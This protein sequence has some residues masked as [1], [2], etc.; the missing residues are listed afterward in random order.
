MSH[1]ISAVLSILPLA[2]PKVPAPET[3]PPTALADRMERLGQALASYRMTLRV[4]PLGSAGQSDLLEE[5]W[6]VDG[7]RWSCRTLHFWPE[8]PDVKLAERL[9]EYS[10][11]V[12]VDGTSRT[13]FRDKSRTA[14]IER[15]A[16]RTSL[17]VVVPTDRLFLRPLGEGDFLDRPVTQV[18]PDGKVYRCL[19]RDLIL[20]EALKH[21]GWVVGPDRMSEGVL[22][23]T[24]RIGPGFEDR[25]WVD[26]ARGFALTAREFH[27]GGEA[28]IRL[29]FD[30]LR[31]L[32][33]GLWIP[34]VYRWWRDGQGFEQRITELTLGSPLPGELT[35]ALPPG[36]RIVDRRDGSVRYLPGGEDMLD[37]MADR[38][39]HLYLSPRSGGGRRGGWATLLPLALVPAAL[40]VVARRRTTNSEGRCGVTLIE[41]LVVIAVIGLLAG[42]LLPGVQSAR[43]ASRR[44]WCA[45]NLRQIG[46]AIHNYEG[47]HRTLPSGRPGR[48][49]PDDVHTGRSVF[50][51]ILPSVGATPVY[52][53]YNFSAMPFNLANATAEMARP[54]LL[55]CP[56]DPAS[57]GPQPGGFGARYPAPDPPSGEWPVMLASYTPLYGTLHYGWETRPNPAYD[58]RGQINGCFND[59]PSITPAG[60]T[61]GLSNTMF[62]SE[63][64]LSHLNAD[65]YN[66]VG[67]WVD[68]FGGA[69]L[70]FATLPPN[71]ALR[72]SSHHPYYATLQVSASSFHPGGVHAL[73]GDGSA[74]F[75]KETIDSWPIDPDRF[76]VVGVIPLPDGYANVPRSGVWQALTTRSGGEAVTPP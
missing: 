4:A 23:L 64:A 45:N 26:P 11:Q 57:H 40:V 44:A 47:T 76:A 58:P 73:M 24:R 10:N 75:V 20:P 69:T 60:I 51:A 37:E 39:R 33:D 36:T 55:V 22:L 43:E 15:P 7:A 67:R 59:L 9:D 48:L 19:W 3:I 46:L 63:R 35:F 16:A 41:L 6:T 31:P 56:S 25:I 72:Q 12:A 50:V 32:I 5:R 53:A 66:P 27:F 18:A 54:G 70:S 34:R 8:Y 28:H 38:V 65:R 17:E 61:D 52:D 13:F 42:L 1:L 2:I 14:W 29:E 21:P 30:D 62:L 74:R 68:S 49:V 71:F